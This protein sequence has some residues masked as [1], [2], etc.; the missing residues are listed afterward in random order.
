MKIAFKLFYRLLLFVFLMF[1]AACAS[2]E[3]VISTPTLMPSTG[4]ATASI[5]SSA[6]TKINQATEMSP[7]TST[8][9]PGMSAT[10][11]IITLETPLTPTPLLPVPIRSPQNGTFGAFLDAKTADGGLTQMIAANA[12]WVHISL[13]WSSIEPRAGRRNWSAVS[14]I[15]SILR[16]AASNQ[17]N[18]I[19]YLQD[20]PSWALKS[21]YT[22]GAVAP[23]KLPDLGHFLTDMVNRYS[24]APFNVKYYELWSEPEVSRFLGCWGD[25]SDT[26]YYG[27]GYYGEMLKTAYPVIKAANPSAQVLFAGLLMDCNPNK[28]A[29]IPSR[30]LEGALVNGAGNFLDGISF[31]AYDYY[32]LQPDQYYSPKWDSSWN[33][34]GPAFLAKAAYLRQLLAQYKIPEKYLINTE[35]ALICGS[36]G[37]E[38]P[39]VTADHEKSV[40]IY[41]V[42]AYAA[43]IADGLRANIWFSVAG[44]RGSA[45][46][47][48]RMAPL[49]SYS[50]LKN[51]GDRLGTAAFVR[52]IT[53]YSGLQGYEF[54]SA[55]H[56]IWVVWSV[57]QEG[58]PHTITLLTA[59]FAVYDMYGGIQPSSMSLPVGI[60]PVYVEFGS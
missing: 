31:H 54:T 26:S 41:A 8:I 37:L 60:E 58:N 9:S 5:E 16:A 45:L 29:D 47:D 2:S 38:A 53:E 49:A 32:Q 33:T 17:L 51:A 23:D 35:L 34:T 56:R 10:Q 55:G 40:S 42:Q 4:K 20:T 28:C 52:K 15:E 1:S 44:W 3:K 27:G 19:L 6:T 13:P 7:A 48:K 22:C 21:G 11:E 18:I 12:A 14:N 25:P 57:T 39:C 30:F 24:A 46:L 36:T 59:P 43:G 50:A